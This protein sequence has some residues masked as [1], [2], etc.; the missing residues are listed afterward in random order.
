MNNGH[1]VSK[2][3]T[4]TL[5][6]VISVQQQR[7]Y[8]YKVLLFSQLYVSKIFTLIIHGFFLSTIKFVKK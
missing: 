7:V 4:C 3:D 6:F 8:G 2:K 1:T 5:D